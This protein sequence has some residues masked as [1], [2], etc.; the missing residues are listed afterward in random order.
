METLQTLF[1]LA[2]DLLATPAEDLAPILLKLARRSVQNGMF[3]P[4]TVPQVVSGTGVAATRHSGY[5]L[6]TIRPLTHY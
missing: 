6:I 3:H 5:P 1:P 4:D 2:E